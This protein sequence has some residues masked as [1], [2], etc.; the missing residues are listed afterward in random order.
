MPDNATTATASSVSVTDWVACYNNGEE[1]IA[2][3]CTAT[4]TKD[5][6]S[7]VGLTLNNQNG[8]TLASIYVELSDNNRS[9]TPAINLP[10]GNLKVGDSVN[11]VVSGE[12][13]GHH[14]FFEQKLKIGTCQPAADSEQKD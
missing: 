6:I 7:G 14:F 12:A 9:V 1:I 11:G 4:S 3:S 2:L 8:M 13:G 5:D 10:V